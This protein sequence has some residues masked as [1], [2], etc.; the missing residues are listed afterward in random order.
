[1]IK[2]YLPLAL[3]LLLSMAVHWQWLNIKDTITHGDWYAFNSTSLSQIRIHHF[4][5]WLEDMNMGRV[6]VDLVQG[7]FWAAF[8]FLYVYFSAD[9]DISNHLLV[10]YPII[11]IAP[12]SVYF[13]LSKLLQNKL[14]IFL[15]SCVYL[16]NSYFLIL[17]TGHLTLAVAYTF[18]PLVF[19]YLISFIENNDNRYLVYALIVNLMVGIVEFR[20]GFISIGLVCLFLVFYKKYWHL[21]FS[22]AVILLSNLYWI[23]PISF[24]NYL[25][26]DTILS[27]DLFGSHFFKQI[28]ALFL[29]HPFWTYGK[30]GVF[31]NH[32][33]SIFSIILPASFFYYLYNY[34]SLNQ[35]FKF[36]SF[37]V[38]LGVLGVFLGKQDN[39]PFG[40][41]YKYFYEN[42]PGFGMYREAT[43]FYLMTSLGFTVSIGTLFASIKNNIVKYV[44][45]LLFLIYQTS[46]LL[47]VISN[48]L[49]S[50]F[51]PRNIPDEYVHFNEKIDAEGDFYRVLWLP[52]LSRWASN[53]PL[54]QNIS[55][56]DFAY[57]SW[58]KFYNPGE[59]VHLDLSRF[60]FKLTDQEFADLA[61][62]YVVVPHTDIYNDDNFFSDYG[63]E[64]PLYISNLYSRFGTPIIYGDLYIFKTNLSNAGLFSFNKSYT[65]S[66]VKLSSVEYVISLDTKYGGDGFVFLET[67]HPNWYL[68]PV[69]GFSWWKAPFL[70]PIADKNHYVE[71]GYANAWNLSQEDLD[72]ARNEKGEVELVLYFLP[73]TY[74]YYGL[75]ISLSTLF[76]LVCYIFYK[77]INKS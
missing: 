8:G 16:F 51:I 1:M 58:L 17:Q 5:T 38:L 57:S 53:S 35:R 43:K 73:Q 70:K 66:F 76:G 21:L 46:I 62:K 48:K 18:V 14:S 37:F 36:T 71:Y 75:T 31:E 69:K 26:S 3:L 72:R 54:H 24:T 7:P 32:Y 12:V 4:G 55:V 77:F 39:Q 25:Y 30:V 33:P 44:L 19:F 15:A 13:F 49:N 23:L 28:D 52:R 42:L 47:P 60:I 45:I 40:Y 67:F 9:F 41:I 64:K 27:R 65:R 34:K 20:Y 22:V 63:N 68:F 59:P 29:Y 6:V 56:T 11:F 2:K 61:I 50:T 74:F 10:L